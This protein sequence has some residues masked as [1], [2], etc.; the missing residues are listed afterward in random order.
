MKIK[1]QLYNKYE[2]I[3]RAMK[4]SINFKITKRTENMMN[5]TSKFFKLSQHTHTHQHTHTLSKQSNFL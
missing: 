3:G 4:Q 5:V 1:E 2:L